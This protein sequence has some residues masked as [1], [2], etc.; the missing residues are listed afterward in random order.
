[1]KLR[2]KN[3]VTKGIIADLRAKGYEKKH[4]ILRAIAMDL[5]RPRRQKI[6]VNLSGID[7]FAGVRETVVVPGTVLGSG[8]ISKAVHVAALKFSAAARKKIEKSGG[9]CLS[10]EDFSEG[11]KKGQKIRIM[12]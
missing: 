3:A 10:I 12:G 2:N 9:K 5:N 7:K 6:E 1:M 8:E 11:Y 4:G